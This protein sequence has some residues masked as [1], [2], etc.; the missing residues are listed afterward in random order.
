MT[1]TGR[2]PD[3]VPTRTFEWGSI[4]W[5]VTPHLDES[6][7]MT[8][9]EVIINPGQGHAPHTHPGEDEVIYVISGEGV[10]T[11]GEG[12]EAFEIREGDAI[13]IPL[14]TVHS[15]YNT[16]WRPLRLV[17]TYTPGGAETM[18]DE[19][20]DARILEPGEVP[21]WVQSPKQ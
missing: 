1:T 2:R 10:Q 17:V 3:D 8:V 7:K 16:T 14:G 18:L 12:A 6:A 11:V 19:L 21:A 4:K 13:Y 9:G 15:T 5:L 20:P